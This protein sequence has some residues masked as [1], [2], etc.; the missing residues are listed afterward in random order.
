[1]YN[2]SM[3]VLIETFDALQIKVILRNKTSIE[4][5]IEEKVRTLTDLQLAKHWYSACQESITCFICSVHSTTTPHC[6][7]NTSIHNKIRKPQREHLRKTWLRFWGAMWS[8]VQ[9]M[10]ICCTTKMKKY[11]WSF[12]MSLLTSCED[13]SQMWIEL[14]FF[15]FQNTAKDNFRIQFFILFTPIIPII[16]L[17]S[18]CRPKTESNTTRRERSLSSRTTWEGAGRTSSRSS[19]GQGHPAETASSGPS[20]QSAT[21]TP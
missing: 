11:I 14:F 9:Q 16:L 2:V 13:L 19:P 3:H 20:T 5:W 12:M 10:A 17:S 4:A 8:F 1:M 18:Y 21:S 6:S 15:L 7:R